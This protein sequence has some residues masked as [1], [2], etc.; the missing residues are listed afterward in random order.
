M[1]QQWGDSAK[2]TQILVIQISQEDKN[3]TKQEAQISIFFP[4]LFCVDECGWCVVI[5]VETSLAKSSG[6]VCTSL[7]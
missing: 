2:E 7:G 3:K 1:H 6:K 4:L 5:W